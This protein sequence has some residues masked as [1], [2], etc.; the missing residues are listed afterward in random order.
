MRMTL[1]LPSL[2]LALAASTTTSTPARADAPDVDVDDLR[3]AK[4]RRFPLLPTAGLVL[5]PSFGA[6]TTRF[7]GGAWLGAAHYPMSGPHTF[8]WS[9]A[10]ALEVQSAGDTIALPWGVDLRLGSAWFSTTRRYLLQGTVYLLG[11]YRFA[12]ALDIGSARF[13]IGASSPAFFL[14]AVRTIFLPV[15]STLELVGVVP[16]D[17]PARFELRFGWSY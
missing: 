5:G 11:G 16:R 7:L 14:S 13:G 4:R 9:L 3:T 6:P 1:A 8:F 17:A 12:S 2:L 10:G 15:P